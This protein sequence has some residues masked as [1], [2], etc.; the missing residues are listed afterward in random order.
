MEYEFKDLGVWQPYMPDTLSPQQQAANAEVAGMGLGPA[1]YLK[2]ESDGK[3]W[4]EFRNAADS[5]ADGAVLVCAL[6]DPATGL[7]TMDATQRDKNLTFP[8]GQRLI[9]VLG[10]D[11]ADPKPFKLFKG[12]IYDPTTNTMS[13]PPP[14]QVQSV[15]DYQFAGQAAAEGIISDDDAMKWVAQ[16]ITPQVLIDAVTASVTDPDR[17]KRVLLFLAGTTAFPRNHELTPL[18]AASFGKDTPAKLDA[19]FYAASLR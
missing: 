18:L 2:R 14:P 1:V 7:E 12:K 19:F 13:D 15:K 8:A 16:G 6:H 9:Q 17:R 11:P 4:Y 3:D 10:V 5:F